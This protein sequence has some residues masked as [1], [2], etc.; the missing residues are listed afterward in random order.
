MLNV[1]YQHR[2]AN[3]KPTRTAPG[4]ACAASPGPWINDSTPALYGT[5]TDGDGSVKVVFDLTGP[6]SPADYTSGSVSSGKEGSWT[7]GTALADGAYKW[8]VKGTDGVAA[9]DT[10]WSGYCY[11]RQDHTPPTLPVITRTSSGTPEIGKPVTLSLSSTDGGS[12][13]KRFEYGIGVDTRE[14][15]V[16]ATSGKASLT[17]TP[18]SGRTQ[19]YVWAQD[20]ALNYSTRAV[21]NVF[22]GRVTP[23]EPRG[24]WRMTHDPRDDSGTIDADGTKSETSAAKDLK[25]TATGV[26]YGSDRRGKSAAALNFDG[27]GCATTIPVVRGDA[28]LTIAAW[29]KLGAKS[30]NRSVVVLAGTNA[31]SLVLAYHAASDRWEAAITNADSTSVTWTVARGT[32]SPPLNTWQH[33]AASLDPAGKVLRLFVDGVTAAEVPITGAW[34][35]GARTMIGCGGNATTVNTQMIGSIDQVGIWSGLLNEAQ[36]AAVANELPA[37]IVAQWEKV[38]SDVL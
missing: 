19:V 4:G 16:T 28:E 34:H 25:F 8:R 36:V 17:F 20:N 37:G 30:V 23:I 38:E 5:A 6:T 13:V 32:S 12:G 18:G 35:G 22:T 10:E 26:T 11:F 33:L 7:V 2:P 3:P 15:P 31:P 27:T 24:I 14:T 9:D 1:E 29:V 21:Y